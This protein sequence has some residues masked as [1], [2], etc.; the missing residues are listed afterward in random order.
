MFSYFYGNEKPTLLERGG[1]FA[2]LARE[3]LGEGGEEDHEE[4]QR[5]ARPVDCA[6][7]DAVT[8]PMKELGGR[9]VLGLVD[10]LA[11]IRPCCLHLVKVDLHEP[12]L[13]P[14]R[15]EVGARVVVRELRLGDLDHRGAAG[16][17]GH[18]ASGCQL[19]VLDQRVLPEDLLEETHRD[20]PEHDGLGV[21]R[22]GGVVG[23]GPCFV[24]D[25]DVGLPTTHAVGDDVDVGCLTV[26]RSFEARAAIAV[27]GDD[28]A[29]RAE[30]APGFPVARLERVL[31]SFVSDGKH[32]GSSCWP[33]L[34]E[35]GFAFFCFGKRDGCCHCR[36]LFS[37]SSGREEGF[38][39]WV[40]QEFSF[41]SRVGVKQKNRC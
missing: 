34:D 10:L 1:R 24:E 20:L 27:A 6:L 25:R 13:G 32:P 15:H 38:V 7:V 14:G 2:L 37:I 21:G 16:L 4:R 35:T 22:I 31:P 40:Y 17:L 33:S 23:V 30:L 39:L 28:V 3:E 41:L 26:L 9:H 19:A 29:D 18:F 12:E 11:A 36:L 8:D 5:G